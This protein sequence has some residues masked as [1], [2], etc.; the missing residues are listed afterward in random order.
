MF[1]YGI[2]LLMQGK[3][4]KESVN[5]AQKKIPDEERTKP[6]SKEEGRG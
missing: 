6:E 2:M 5:F 3:I 4:F 1:V